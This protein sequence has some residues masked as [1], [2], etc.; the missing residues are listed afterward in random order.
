MQ[1]H[2]EWKT[3]DTSSGAFE[4]L[5]RCNSCSLRLPA[6]SGG[7]VQYMAIVSCPATMAALGHQP[8]NVQNALSVSC[9]EQVKG[10]GCDVKMSVRTRVR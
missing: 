6:R 10:G 1:A 2:L 4:S 8:S 5:K 7:L 9:L 3:L